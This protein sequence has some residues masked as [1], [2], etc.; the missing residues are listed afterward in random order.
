METIPYKL[1]IER[2][3]MC[4]IAEV[5]CCL[6]GHQIR[7]WQYLPYFCGISVEKSSMSNFKVRYPIYLLSTYYDKT[8]LKTI[9]HV[10]IENSVAFYNEM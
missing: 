1:Y 3:N 9:L 4:L 2:I 5:I 10:L 6:S 7:P 8:I